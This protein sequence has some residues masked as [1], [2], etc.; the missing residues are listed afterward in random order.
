MLRLAGVLLV[1]AFVAA[2]GAT[3]KV[4]ER[5]SRFTDLSHRSDAFDPSESG[6]ST[7]SWRIVWRY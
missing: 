5:C 3:L 1:L 6:R 4:E 7:C 2:A